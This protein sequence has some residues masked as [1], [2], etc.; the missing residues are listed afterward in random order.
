MSCAPGG[1]H[2]RGRWEPLSPSC[3]RAVASAGG[4]QRI[5]ARNPVGFGS[6]KTGDRARSP[7][8]VRAPW[9]ARGCLC[10]RAVRGMSHATDC[11]GVETEGGGGGGGWPGAAA[12]E[13]VI[14][15]AWRQTARGASSCRGTGWAWEQ[16]TRMRAQAPTP[17]TREERGMS[18]RWEQL[19]V[20]KDE[21]E[22]AIQEHEANVVPRLVTL[23]T[24]HGH[25]SVVNFGWPRTVRG[26]GS[27][28]C[29]A[30]AGD[31]RRLR[32]T[33]RSLVWPA[34]ASRTGGRGP[35]RS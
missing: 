29:C 2:S 16:H 32:C 11:P 30:D 12:M 34:R 8:V 14:F 27:R 7:G 26:F 9:S 15:A 4:K 35:V 19:A 33:R 23:P 6:E 17:T 13:R 22:R 3:A 20:R 31:C 10:G 24:N 18:V 1:G 28:G 21:V 25:S 5:F